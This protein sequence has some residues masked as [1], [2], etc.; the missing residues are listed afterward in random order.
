MRLPFRE[1]NLL[2]ALSEANG[3]EPVDLLR[4]LISNEAEQEYG[5]ISHCAETSEPLGFDRADLVAWWR[6]RTASR[7]GDQPKGSDSAPKVRAARKVAAKKRATKK[8]PRG[9]P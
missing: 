2:L 7:A 4:E 3:G 9:K 6:E 8:G 1:W 5:W